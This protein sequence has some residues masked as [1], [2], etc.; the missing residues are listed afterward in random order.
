MEGD[1]CSV[2]WNSADRQNSVGAKPAESLVEPNWNA[3]WFRATAIP[4][5]IQFCAARN[6]S[7]AKI[8]QREGLSTIRPESMIVVIGRRSKI[9]WCYGVLG[10]AD[11]GPE[12]G[13]RFQ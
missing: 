8:F 1:S 13:A 6:D 9:C 12:D 5:V 2:P 4:D 10:F 7:G 3:L 11:K